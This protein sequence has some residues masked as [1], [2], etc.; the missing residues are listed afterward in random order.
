MAFDI[1]PHDI[2]DEPESTGKLMGHVAV[3]MI[4]D[5]GEL[6]REVKRIVRGS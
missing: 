6:M 2:K 3:Q 4:G 1:Q 5:A